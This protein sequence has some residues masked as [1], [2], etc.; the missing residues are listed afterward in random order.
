VP[1]RGMIPA[2]RRLTAA[3]LLA[4][5]MALVAC[6]DDDSTT[7]TETAPPTGTAETTEAAGT[8]PEGELTTTGIGG[9]S[10]GMSTEEVRALFGE[11]DRTQKGPGCELAPQAKGA[12]AWTYRLDDGEVIL[13]FDAASGQLGFYRTT[14]PSLETALGDRVGDRFAGLRRNWGSDLEPLPIGEPTPKA[15]FWIVKDEEDPRSWLNFDVRGGKVAAILG[16]HI[17][18]CE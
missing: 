4:L 18:V 5:S 10:Q 9:V 2:M 12:I 13:N 3:S 11:P 15:G 16:G 6:G 7:A 8:G 1:K 14:S 17:E